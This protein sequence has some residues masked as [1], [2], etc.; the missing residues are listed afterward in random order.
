MNMTK[1]EKGLHQAR[2][3]FNEKIIE[4]AD[5]AIEDSSTYSEATKKLADFRWSFT[6]KT[7]QLMIDSAIDTV[8]QKALMSETKNTA[9]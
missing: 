6:G 1:L 3:Q 7:A 4:L 9:V 8:Q 2:K 5:M